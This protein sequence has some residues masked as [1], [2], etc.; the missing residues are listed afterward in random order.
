[1]IEPSQLPNQSL[2]IESTQKV[3]HL[4]NVLPNGIIRNSDVV[5]DVVET[6]LSIGLVKIE[7][8]QLTATILAR[9]LIESG[10]E[11]VRGK[12]NSLAT[13]TGAKVA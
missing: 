8:Q 3:I 10:K 11:D 6:S 1:E 12:I 4:L 13:L 7:E 5:K 2:T 9:S